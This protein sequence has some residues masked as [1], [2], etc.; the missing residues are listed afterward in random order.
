MFYFFELIFVGLI[1]LVTDFFREYYA[2]MPSS[3]RGLAALCGPP[4]SAVVFGTM[5][6]IRVS[7]EPGVIDAANDRI[8]AFSTCR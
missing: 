1:G 6:I 4:D 3:V 5:C 2:F 7:A 8:K